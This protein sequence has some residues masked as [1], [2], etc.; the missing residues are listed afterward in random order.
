MAIMNAIDKRLWGGPLRIM[1]SQMQ[2][3]SIA[4]PRKRAGELPP[5]T[6]PIA[7]HRA[8][9]K[10]RLPARVDAVGLMHQVQ[11]PN[12]A[13]ICVEL[14]LLKLRRDIE[15]RL[16]ADMAELL[17]IA[18]HMSGRLVSDRDRPGRQYRQMRRSGLICRLATLARL[19]RDRHI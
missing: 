13:A 4:A 10:H 16:R 18:L 1:A 9:P 14:H 11:H 2:P 12:R 5:S 6:I 17:P 3:H 8:E 19:Y 15:E 7:P